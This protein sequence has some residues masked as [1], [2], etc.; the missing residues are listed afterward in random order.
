[1]GKIKDLIT[2]KDNVNP[3]A[4]KK[5]KTLSDSIDVKKPI[6]VTAPLKDTI[7]VKKPQTST[8]VVVDI[9]KDSVYEAPKEAPK[10]KLDNVNEIVY[11]K[12]ARDLGNVY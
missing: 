9:S 12:T 8:A 5:A 10:V 3:E 4:K 6:K 11:R 1:M 2:D 7:D